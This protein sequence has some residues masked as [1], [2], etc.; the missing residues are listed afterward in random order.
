MANSCSEFCAT[1]SVGGTILLWNGQLVNRSTTLKGRPTLCRGKNLS[2][3][4]QAFIAKQL[5]LD[6]SLSLGKEAHSYYIYIYIYICIMYVETHIIVIV[7]SIFGTL[8]V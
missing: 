5:N 8:H 2:E 4:E 6:I 7:W 3:K 1:D